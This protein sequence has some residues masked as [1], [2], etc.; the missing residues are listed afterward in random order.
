MLRNDHE[1][2]YLLEYITKNIEYFKTIPQA[3]VK[4]IVRKLGA[5]EFK[6]GDVVMNQGDE[7]DRMYIVYSGEA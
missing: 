5:E 4:I 2:L 7:A 6:K 3:L 1:R